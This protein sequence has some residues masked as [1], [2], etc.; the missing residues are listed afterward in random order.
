MMSHQQKLF[1]Q[2]SEQQEGE[3]E[4]EEEEEEEGEHETCTNLKR[5]PLREGPNLTSI[6]GLIHV[7]DLNLITQILV[8]VPCQTCSVYAT[9]QFGWYT[10][11]LYYTKLGPI[12]RKVS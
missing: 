5:P 7:N 2:K 10:C 4:E 9:K 3:E 6:A 1:P 11:Y 12:F 8:S